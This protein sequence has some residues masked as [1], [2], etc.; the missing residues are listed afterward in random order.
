MAKKSKKYFPIFVDLTDKKVVVV[1]AGTIAKRRIRVLV[2]F[3]EHL[4][5]IAPEVNPELKELEAAGQLTI[6]RKTYEREDI[7]DA[8]YVI[9]AT[10]DSRLN[11]EIYTDCKCLGIPV[12]VSSD[13]TQ[14]DF[15]FPV[16]AYDECIVAGIS[17]GGQDSS[18]SRRMA[19]RIQKLFEEMGE[20]T[21]Q[22][23]KENEKE[24]DSGLNFCSDSDSRDSDSR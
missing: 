9:A 22:S 2:D 23:E 4:Y 7:Y 11:H 19:D 3:T 17:S 16:L 15:F 10:S 20:Q 14:C 6:L 13:K 5:E 1:G 24:K 12:N 8:S 18:R 21:G